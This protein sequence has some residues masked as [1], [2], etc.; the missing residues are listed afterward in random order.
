MLIRPFF[1]YG[2]IKQVV[3]RPRANFAL[4]PR[5]FPVLQCYSTHLA[6]RMSSQPTSLSPKY[7]L[8]FFVPLSHVEVCKEAVFATGAGSYPQGKYSKACF[9]SLGTGQFL[10]GDGA[11]PNIGQVGE[12]EKVEEMRV[13]ILCL[14]RETMLR[15][16]DELLKAHPYEEPGYEVYKLEDIR[17]D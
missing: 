3:S 1:H 16:V 12:V 17:G 9:Q 4:R 13:E 11:N 14:G 5:V 7:K 8:V 2:T 15:A 10:P 6:R